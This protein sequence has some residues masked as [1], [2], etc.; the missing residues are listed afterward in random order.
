[1]SYENDNRV[2]VHKIFAERTEQIELDRDREQ[3]EQ[4][5]AVIKEII[6]HTYS[7]A[8]SYSNVIIAAGYV[9]F[10]TLWSG[11][12]KDI[13]DWAVLTSGAL[14]LLSLM[15]FIGF[16]LYKM[17]SGAVHM[18][19]ITNRIRQPTM[20]TLAEIQHIEQQTNLWNARIWV[21]T[22]IPTV[23]SGLLA[24][25]VLLTGFLIKFSVQYT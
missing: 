6:S 25:L 2:D 9:G 1:M 20:D 11:I 22:L 10:F 16:E 17:I 24:G 15:I 18:R 4:N 14:I 3:V 21:F 12:K 19:K 5:V 23:I 8:N 13:P 7:K